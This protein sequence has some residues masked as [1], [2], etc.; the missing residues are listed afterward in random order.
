VLQVVV[1]VVA[2]G[3]WP[4]CEGSRLEFFRF[5]GLSVISVARQRNNFVIPISVSDDV[6]KAFSVRFLT[7]ILL[8]KK[9][10]KQN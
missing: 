7:S 3:F 10:E 5:S 4:S 2:F 8:R 1:V 9:E 6:K